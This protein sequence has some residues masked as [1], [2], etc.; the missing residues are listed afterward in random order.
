MDPVP[1][2]SPKLLKTL[3]ITFGNAKKSEFNF[4]RSAFFFGSPYLVL[5]SSTI[6]VL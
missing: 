5:N 6:T 3:R 4:Q 2:E 1:F